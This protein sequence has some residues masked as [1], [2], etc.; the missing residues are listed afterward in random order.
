MIMIISVP[1]IIMHHKYIV[2]R[3][4]KFFHQ[5]MHKKILYVYI[6]KMSTVTP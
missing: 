6:T 1:L 4:S 3:F 5:L 2:D